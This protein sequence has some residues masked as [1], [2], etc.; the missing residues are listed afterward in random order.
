MGD[1]KVQVA[2]E[3]IKRIRQLIA[4]PNQYNQSTSSNRTNVL[5]TGHV[6]EHAADLARE[7]DDGACNMGDRVTSNHILLICATM[8]VVL[9]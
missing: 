6:M 1:K 8:N 3:S 9:D 2:R 4:E 7:Q 5:W